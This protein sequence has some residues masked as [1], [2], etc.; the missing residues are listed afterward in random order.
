[1]VEKA[2]LD[3]KSIPQTNLLLFPFLGQIQPAG[4]YKGPALITIEKCPSKNENKIYN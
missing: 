3:M 2:Y 4:K 1:M